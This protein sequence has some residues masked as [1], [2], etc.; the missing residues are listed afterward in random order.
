[1]DGKTFVVTVPDGGIGEGDN[2]EVPYPKTT[3]A[4]TDAI[5]IAAA[6]VAVPAADAVTNKNEV[7]AFEVPT[8][9]WRHGLFDCFSSCCCPFAMGLCCFPILMGQNMQRLK[10]NFLGCERAEGSSEQPPI[11]MVY[12]AITLIL[13]LFGSLILALTKR[14]GYIVWAI[15]G[16]YM[17]IVFTCARMTMRKKYKIKPGCCGD[18]CLDDCCNVYW[19][20]CC[21]AI[22]M[23]RHTHDEN[24]YH[25]NCS[26][27]TG[28]NPDAPEIV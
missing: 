3:N 5:P 20:S 22:Q 27:Q 26:S 21:T 19:C 10:L 9:Q 23:A 7:V 1:V 25:Y 2:F 12:T 16:W 28:L 14:Y 4:D 18:N 8:G 17:L 24:E 13:L 11:C 6:A 15:W